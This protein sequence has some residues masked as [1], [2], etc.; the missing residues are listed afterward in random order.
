MILLQVPLGGNQFRQRDESLDRPRKISFETV[1]FRAGDQVE[2]VESAVMDM[3][4]DWYADP[5]QSGCVGEANRS[6]LLTAMSV[7]SMQASLAIRADTREGLCSASLQGGFGDA[8][9]APVA[10]M[11]MLATFQ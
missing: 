3:K 9:R 2:A 1:G 4:F 11:S 5:C 8:V 10:A 6:R 7:G